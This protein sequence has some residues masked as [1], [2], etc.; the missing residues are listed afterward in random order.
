MAGLLLV[1]TIRAAHFIAHAARAVTFRFGLDYGEGTVWQQAL[2]IPGPRMYGEVTHAPFIAFEY[3]PVYHLLV[4]ALVAV[5]IDPL[6]AGRGISLTATIV[7]AVLAGSI[8]F[9]ATQQSAS[10]GA[11]ILG[12]VLAALIVF[13]YRPVAESAVL[14]HVDVLAITFSFAGV[15]LAIIAGH[16]TFT[17]CVAVLL[18]SLA[19]YTKQT[20]LSAPIATLLVAAIID[21]RSAL[22]AAAFGLII[23]G[24][25]LII[26]LV[27]TD[28]GFW[29]HVIV[30]NAHNRFIPQN[31]IYLLLRQKGDALGLLTRIVAFGFLWWTEATQHR[32]RDLGT[33]GA[34]LRQS[35]KLR[36]VSIGSLWFVLASA[37]LVTLGRPGSWD[38]YFV[39]W[40]CITAIPIGMTATIAWAGLSSGLKLHRCPCLRE[41]SYH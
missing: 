21:L 31:I 9:T 3:P 27:A 18:F 10:T 24:A 38:N 39:E 15:Y 36:T 19:V 35:K 37:Q 7:I 26:L 30:Y 8:A 28:G 33:W 22:K 29:R 16:R 12:S 23:S 34:A 6:T 41:V 32:V 13:T 20:E 25:D 5:G 17:L 2:L 11:R 1:L 4:R 14:M 40:M